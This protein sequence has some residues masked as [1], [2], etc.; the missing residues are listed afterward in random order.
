MPAVA[1]PRRA[2]RWGERLNDRW[3]QSWIRSTED[4]SRLQYSHRMLDAVIDEIDG[5]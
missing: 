2:L 1:D 5:R 4:L 3:L